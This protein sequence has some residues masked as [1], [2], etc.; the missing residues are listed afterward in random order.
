MWG[1]FVGEGSNITVEEGE[2]VIIEEATGVRVGRSVAV[3][4]GGGNGVRVGCKLLAG[5]VEVP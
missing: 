1:L 5:S 2:D 3:W 4:P